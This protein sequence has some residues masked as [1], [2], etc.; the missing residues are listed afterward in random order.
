MDARM[1]HH[2]GKVLPIPP[3]TE[4][5][6]RRELVH[7]IVWSKFVLLGEQV[8]QPSTTKRGG[9]KSGHHRHEMVLAIPAI[10]SPHAA[11]RDHL[12]SWQ[13][14]EIGDLRPTCDAE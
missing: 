1:E 4:N 6:D 5:F 8:H 10:P 9:T 13:H 12:R 14:L 3:S 7:G 2:R 11:N